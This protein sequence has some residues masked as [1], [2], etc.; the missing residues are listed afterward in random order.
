M[1]GAGQHVF[2]LFFDPARYDLSRV[3]RYKYNK[4]LAVGPRVAGRTLTRPVADPMTG[5]VL[6]EEGTIVSR[7]MAHQFDDKGVSECLC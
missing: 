7:E 1:E 6:A 4:K 5:E 2:S 3:G